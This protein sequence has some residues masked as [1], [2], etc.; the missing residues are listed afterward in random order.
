MRTQNQLLSI[1]LGFF[2]VAGCAG[3]HQQI[4]VSARPAGKPAAE[5][6]VTWRPA[7]ADRVKLEYRQ[8]GRPNEIVEL[9]EKA[10]RHR[11]ALFDIAKS[12]HGKAGTISAWRVTVWQGE[13]L[14]AERKSA[15][16]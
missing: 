12:C 14:L 3:P 6:Y 4:A 1:G 13:L 9:S 5:V 10:D 15:L 16:W 7:S 11:A 2:L 8:A